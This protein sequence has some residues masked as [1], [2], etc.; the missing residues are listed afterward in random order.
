MAA[1]SRRG[2]ITEALPNELFRVRL[3]GGE[4]VLAHLSTGVRLRLVRL[5]LGDRVQVELSSFDPH[6]GRITAAG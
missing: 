4:E 2:V 5:L 6:R 1:A 3:D